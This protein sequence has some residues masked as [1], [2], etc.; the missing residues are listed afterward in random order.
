MFPGFEA[1]QLGIL[2]ILQII[3]IIS[4]PLHIVVLSDYDNRFKLVKWIVEKCRRI[5]REKAYKNT[6][7]MRTVKWSGMEK[8]VMGHQV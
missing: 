3:I 7:N 8:G 5:Y 4:R 1:T 2:I 6:Q